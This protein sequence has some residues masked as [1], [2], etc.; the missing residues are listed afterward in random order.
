M[1]IWRGWGIL[2]AILLFGG[3]VAAQFVADAV[4]GKGTYAANTFLYAGLGLI[5]GGGL[6]FLFARWEKGRNPPRV[7]ADKETGQEVTLQNRSDLFFVPMKYW[8]LLGIGAGVVAMIAGLL[9]AR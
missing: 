3:L 4:G 7:L 6:T 1:I 5:V 2:A 8:G 9:G